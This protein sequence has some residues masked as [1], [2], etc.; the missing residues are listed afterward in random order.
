MI[1]TFILNVISSFMKMDL[2]N[3]SSLEMFDSKLF[4]IEVVLKGMFL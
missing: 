4:S 3:Y 2:A 1:L